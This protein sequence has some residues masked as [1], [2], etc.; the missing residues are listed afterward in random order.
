MSSGRGRGVQAEAGV[1]QAAQEMMASSRSSC[2]PS[3]SP[4]LGVI[5]ISWLASATAGIAGVAGSI[6]SSR[7]SRASLC[8]KRT[9]AGAAA[10]AA[11][12]SFGEAWGA[13]AS[14]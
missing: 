8:R 10:A 2:K 7:L 14:R 9:G 13:G 12:S 4:A 3:D 11:A 1:G 6:S 5:P